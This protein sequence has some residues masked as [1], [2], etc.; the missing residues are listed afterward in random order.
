MVKSIYHI[1][2]LRPIVHNTIYKVD[3]EHPPSY[4]YI[5]I[6]HMYMYHEHGR[7]WVVFNVIVASN[8]HHIVF[9]Q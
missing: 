2:S 4:Q 1:V 9:Y 6:I 3:T 7:I 8:L 5:F